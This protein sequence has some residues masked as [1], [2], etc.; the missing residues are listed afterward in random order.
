VAQVKAGDTLPHLKRL[1][2]EWVRPH[3]AAIALVL[4]F[5]T[6]A[7]AA[8]ALYPLLVREAMHLLDRRDFDTLAWAPVAVV[9]VT[10]TKGFSMFMQ[11]VLTNRFVTRIEADMQA[12]LYAHLIDADLARLGRESAASLTQRFSTDFS[13]IKEA[14][15]R[16]FVV[17]FR[18]IAMLMGLIAVLLYLDPWSTLIAAVIAPFA[19]PPIA[20]IGKKLRRLSTATQ[21]ETGQMAASVSES[22]AG[23]RVAKAYR[24]EPYL[25]DRARSS[26]EDIRALKMKA[27]NAKARLEP[28]LETGAGVAVAL[29][30]VFVGWRLQAGLATLGD[31]AA[32]A[33]ALLMASQ[34]IRTLGNLN[35]I[36]QE[37][38]GAL[39]RFHEVMDEAP[40][41]TEKHGAPALAVSGGAVAFEAV[42]FTYGDGQALDGVSFVA[43]AGKTTALVGP[44]G[45]GKSTLLSLVLRL[46][47]VGGGRVM[48]DGQ[49]VRD[50]TLA[51]LRQATAIVAQDVVLFDDTIRA[52]IALARPGATDA[53]IEEAARAAAAHD[54]IIAQPQGYLTRVG[55]RG[56]RLSGG[57]RQRIALARAFLKDAPILLLDEA[58]SAL[59]AQSE[60][61]VQEAIARL[62]KGRTA[63]VVAHRLSTVRDADRIIVLDRGKITETGT[64]QA[65]IDASGTYA[66]L[67]GLQV[68]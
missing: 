5:V 50:V 8:N 35:A 27:A 14:L 59:D 66:T 34:P 15:T 47:D 68:R 67:H 60:T 19:I 55:D 45:S 29:V 17:F 51:S 63:I 16:L 30:I 62:M 21:E 33:G 3:R 46:H 6:I 7:A 10:G 36:V 25:K 58:T 53:E 18:D 37:A 48:I 56:S 64:H 32:Y 43:E 23:A 26:F 22:L 49:D 1:W 31:F 44:S 13:F 65:L 24:M 40:R 12:A 61:L 42:T 4:V 39:I 52:N 11:T 41:I 57:E 54:F 28:M 20:R 2:R 9:L 38:I